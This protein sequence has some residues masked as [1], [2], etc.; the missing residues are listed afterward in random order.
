MKG[1]PNLGIRLAQAQHPRSLRDERRLGAFGS[2]Q[3]AE[4]LLEIGPTVSNLRCQGLH[5]LDI[6]GIDIEP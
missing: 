6:V 2:L 3:N 5:S 4:G 1:I